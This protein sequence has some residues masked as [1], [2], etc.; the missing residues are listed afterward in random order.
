MKTAGPV[1]GRRARG[2]SSKAEIG[3]I[4]RS[5][6][7]ETRA[8]AHADLFEF[9]ELC[10]DRQRHRAGLATSPQPNTLTRGDYGPVLGQLSSPPNGDHP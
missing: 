9:I 7:F 8:D 3:W 4:R 6:W 2:R 5:I 10:Y 1:A